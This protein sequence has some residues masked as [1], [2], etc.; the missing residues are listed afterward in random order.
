MNTTELILL[1]AGALVFTISFLLPTGKKEKKEEVQKTT[2]KV[3]A[4]STASQRRQA[5]KERQA[6]RKAAR[7]Q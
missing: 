3:D 4:V 2:K 1:I 7:K 6:K 5:R